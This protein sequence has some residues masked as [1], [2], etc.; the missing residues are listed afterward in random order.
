MPQNH[1]CTRRKFIKASSL[2]T[3]ALG[4]G[5]GVLHAMAPRPLRQGRLLDP[6]AKMNIACVGCGGK[7]TSDIVSVSSENIVGL[8]D[9]DPGQAQKIFQQFP[10]APKFK[11]YRA[12]LRELDHRIDAV[13]ISTPDHMHFPIGMLAISLGKHVFIQK[14]LTHTVGEARELLHAA[15]R[16]RVV[17]QMGNQGH[18]GEGVRLLREWVQAGVIGDVREVHIWTSKMR[19]GSYKSDRKIRPDSGEVIPANLDWDLWLGTAQ[20]RPYSNE[21]HP[22]KWRSWW[23]FGGGAL[24]DIGCH[25]MDAAFFALD[26]GAPPT[27]R[28]ETAPFNDETYPDWSVITYEFPARGSLPPVKLTWYDGGKMPE[29]PREL[30][31]TRVLEPENGYILVGDKG[32]IYD[33]SEKCSSPRLIPEE[34]MRSTKFPAKTIRRVPNGDLFQE[35]IAACKGGPT[36]G[37]N[38]EYAATLTEMVLLGNVAIRARGKKLEWDSLRMRIPNAPALERHLMP[39][40]WKG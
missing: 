28:A 11:D 15:R 13:T 30:E 18:A 5:E 32:V 23:E 7:G 4:L 33:P 31:S 38:F 9:V 20:R 6:A 22:R 16:H 37:S 34:R 40:R 2:T 8:C 36:P 1:A 24:G 19:I 10:D 12:M 25:T 39:T 35:W 17:T 29:R 21:Y 3:I 27:V 14:P 26:L